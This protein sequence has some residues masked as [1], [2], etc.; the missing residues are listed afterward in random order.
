MDDTEVK[1]AVP[2]RKFRSI[3]RR[4]RKFQGNQF[5]DTLSSKRK[6][7]QGARNTASHG[8]LRPIIVDETGDQI[9]HSTPL[10]KA[11][12]RSVSSRKIDSS[13]SPIKKVG[14]IEEGTGFRFMDLDVLGSV[15]QLFACP[16]C[17]EKGMNLYEIPKKKMGCASCLQLQCSTCGWIHDFYTS[18]NSST[19][20]DINIRLVY[21]MRCIGQSYAGAR[22]FCGLM[23]IPGVPTENNFDKI[24]RRLKTKVFKVAED[25]MIAASRELHADDRADKVITCGFSVDG[26]WQKRGYASLNGCVAAISIDTGKILDIEAMSRYC[27]GCQKH[28]KDNRDSPDHLL[29]K[30]NHICN[31]NYIGSAPAMEPEGAQ[32]IFKRSKEK[33]NLIYKYF[34]GDGDSKSFSLIE[35]AYKDDGIKVVKYECIG[36]VQKRVGTALR[37]LRKEKKLG[38]KGKLTDKMI[39]RLQNYYGVAVRSSKGDLEGMKSAILAGLF[40][41]AS[42]EGREYHTYCPD[43]L[44]SWCKFKSDR[45]KGTHTYKAGAGLPVSII[46]EV[47]PIFFRLSSDELLGQCLHGKTQNQNESFNGM[48]WE[49][50]PKTEYVGRDTFEFGVFDAVAHF[51]LGAVAAINV[52]K[53]CGIAPGKYTRES[54]KLRNQRRLYFA[55]SKE[56]EKSKLRRKQLRGKR[57]SKDDKKQQEEGES[58]GSG[59]F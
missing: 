43:G 53:E 33:H 24:S 25:S 8:S 22:K 14:N 18:T 51:N 37:K 2:R 29:W 38:G 21:A 30:A 35:N 1:R 15:F 6:R 49:R 27:K 4:K 17:C 39:D 20:Y 3:K 59:K 45:A 31:A 44:D 7:V 48:I 54:C 10:S 47:K 56:K 50:C 36:H 26:T 11:E 12:E 55:E 28:E 40:H 16:D 32:R 13:L 5:C 46:K 42:S 19:T 23:N 58:Y 52:Y 41:C 34:Y 57:K 9:W